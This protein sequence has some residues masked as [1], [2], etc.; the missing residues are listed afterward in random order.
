MVSLVH[1]GRKLGRVIHVK[2]GDDRNGPVVVTLEPSATFTGRIVDGDGNPVSGATIKPIPKPGGDFSLSLPQVACGKD[3]KFNVPDV[4]TGC[5]YS[6][7]F[8]SSAP[9]MRRR[10]VVKAA[11]VRPGETTDVGDIRLKD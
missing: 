2:E 9:A 4:P 6:L 5:E 3:G 11:A 10:F 1:E 8:E 7:L